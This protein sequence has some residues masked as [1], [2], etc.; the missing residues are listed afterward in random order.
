M[1][2]EERATD[3]RK[4]YSNN[5]YP[6]IGLPKWLFKDIDFETSFVAIT[7]CRNGGSHLSIVGVGKDPVGCNCEAKR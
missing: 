4:V 7:P 2:T 6:T 3:V 5:G 1:S